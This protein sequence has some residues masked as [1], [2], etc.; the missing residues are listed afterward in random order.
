MLYTKL[1]STSSAVLQRFKRRASV[2]SSKIHKWYYCVF[3]Q[4]GRWR[5]SWIW[6]DSGRV[7]FLPCYRQTKLQFSSARQKHNSWTGAYK[8]LCVILRDLSA[9]R[10]ILPV[11]YSCKHKLFLHLRA[12]WIFHVGDTERQPTNQNNCRKTQD[13]FKVAQNSFQHFPRRRFWWVIITILY[14]L[15]LQSWYQKTAQSLV[16]TLVLFPCNYR[17]P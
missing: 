13:W 11:R 1:R 14:Q 4:G 2:E 17:L 6:L 3:P 5:L 9:V 12:L 16:N 10:G 7:D 8:I 15:M